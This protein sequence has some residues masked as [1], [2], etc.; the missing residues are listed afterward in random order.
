MTIM[1]LSPWLRS[2]RLASAVSALS[3]CPNTA[4]RP[5]SLILILNLIKAL[6]LRVVAVA[7]RLDVFSSVPFQGGPWLRLG[8]R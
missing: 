3:F 5:N 1:V 4:A 7:A 8:L 2:M 6:E